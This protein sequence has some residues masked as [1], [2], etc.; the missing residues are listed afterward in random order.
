MVVDGGSTD[1]TVE[2]LKR[3]S[4]QR[5]TDTYQLRFV[6]EAD[7]GMYD[8]LNKGFDSASG[9]VFAWLNCDEQY[10]PG[11]LQKVE[12][13][14]GAKPSVDILFGG[15]VM[16]DPEGEF[17]ACRKAMPMRRNFLEVSYLYNFS[18]AMFIHRSL[19]E[20]LGRF[21]V[22]YQNAGDEEWVRRA[23][24]IGAKTATLNDYLAAFTY[25]DQ[26]LSSASGA[27][28]EHEVLKRSSSG[29]SRL[30][31]IPFNL[32][33]I[34]EKMIR[35]GHLQRT[36]FAYEIYGEKEV[37]RKRFN[38]VRPTCLWPDERTPY[39]LSH[40]LKRRWFDGF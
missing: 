9:Q 27:L 32:V 12:A 24:S 18:C 19:W 36:P 22:E 14:L 40:R 8:A 28:E 16:V 26:N 13:S 3:V 34:A 38:V 15:M 5:A 1:G 6:S 4:R 23:L 2:W 7:D 11:T 33:R 35:G 10:L 37:G 21:D 20:I 25:S 17:L 31:K 30:L 39:L 29:V